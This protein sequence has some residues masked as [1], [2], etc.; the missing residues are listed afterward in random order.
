M[1]SKELLFEVKYP[2]KGEWI[3][4]SETVFLQ[5]LL[6]AFDRISPLLI[7]SKVFRHQIKNVLYECT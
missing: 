5:D 4:V 3:E 7:R 1:N 6:K 2:Y